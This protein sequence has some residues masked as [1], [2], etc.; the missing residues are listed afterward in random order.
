[1]KPRR[2]A[3]ILNVVR[4]MALAMIRNDKPLKE[5]DKVVADFLYINNVMATKRQI[6]E[7]VDSLYPLIEAEV[8]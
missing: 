8:I 6:E 5:V 2:Y 1:M 3:H 7:F 4:C